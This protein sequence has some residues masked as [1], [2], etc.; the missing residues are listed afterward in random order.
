MDKAF[1]GLIGVALGV[2]LGILKDWILQSMKRK[3]EYEYLAIRVVC[4]LDHFVYGCVDVVNDDG[5]SHG[6]YD[7]DG[8]ARVQ[9]I[10][11][12]FTPLD[13]DVEW[14]SL[15][16]K[17]M[18]EILSLPNKIEYSNEV[19]TSSFDL[20]ATP[21][22]YEEGFEARQREYSELGV[23]TLELAVKLR[24]FASLPALEYSEYWNPRKILREKKIEIAKLQEARRKAHEELSNKLQLGA[25]NA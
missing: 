7:K 19:I 15:P 11:P 4:E 3:K 17:L 24:K 16:H 23:F 14:K 21:P 8:C 12:E 18:Y 22:Y 1:I 20:A 10:P 6:Q 9:I 25:K 5:T 13:L 2:F